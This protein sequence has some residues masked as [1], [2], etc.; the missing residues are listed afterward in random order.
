MLR[1]HATAIALIWLLLVAT[2]DCPAADF[3][4]NEGFSKLTQLAEGLLRGDHVRRRVPGFEI[5]LLRDGQPVYHRA[6]GDWELGR[7]AQTD[8]SSKTLAGGL[9]MSVV[10]SGEQGFSLDSRLGEFLPEFAKGELAPITVRQAFS[11]SSGIKGQDV[12]SL[13][14]RTKRIELRQG[15]R[16]IA[17][18]SL[19]HGPPGS[20]FAYGGLS[21]Q[22]TGAALEA[23]TGTP[24]CELFAE[25]ITGPLGMHHTRYTLASDS[26]PRVAGGVQSTAADFSRY[27]DMLLNHGVDRP[28]GRRV[29]SAQAVNAL[30]TRQTNESLP[31]DHSPVDNN[32]Y[33]IGVWLD[34][35]AEPGPA[36]D[37][38]AGGARGFHSWIDRGRGLV[39]TLSTDETTFANLEPAAELMRAAVVEELAGAQR[40][41]DL[42]GQSN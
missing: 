6:F 13:I 29:L 8:S 41:Q 3:A 19:E 28:S 11:H 5:L 34:Q 40:L 2:P 21:M 39:L 1:E 30:L 14:L 31:I 37:A 33:G 9:V 38:M 16:L 20:R 35:L 23:A 12:G 4:H 27:M 24:Y 18:Q 7:L 15:A 22:A 32:R 26:N 25:R 42:P 17:R 36:V 10:D